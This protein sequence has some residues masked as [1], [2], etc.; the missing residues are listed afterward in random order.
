[1][2]NVFSCLFFFLRSSC[3]P[4]VLTVFLATLAIGF[5]CLQ[6]IKITPEI[7][8]LDLKE[9]TWTNG[10]YVYNKYTNK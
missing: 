1:L 6:K 3:S 4:D 10:Q 7:G 5:H 8:E 2:W 9:K